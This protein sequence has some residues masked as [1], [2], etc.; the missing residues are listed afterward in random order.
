MAHFSN[1]LLIEL[2]KLYEVNIIHHVESAI[3]FFPINISDKEHTHFK[4]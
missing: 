1:S 3:T 4:K 2:D